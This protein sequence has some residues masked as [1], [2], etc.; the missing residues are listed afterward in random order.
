MKNKRENVKHKFTADFETTTAKVSKTHTRVWAWSVCNIYDHD[1]IVYGEDIGSFIEFAF[2]CKQNV[3][4][5]HNLK[6]DGIFIIDYLLRNGYTC[7]KQNEDIKDKSFSVLINETNVMY[8]ITVY[9]KKKSVKA[10][11]K[12]RP[13]YNKVK[14]ID[15]LKILPYSVDAI[16]KAFKL[17]LS[18]L[19]V[20]YDLDRPIGH[21]LTDEEREYIKHDVLIM[22]KALKITFESG[23]K[24]ITAGSN[25]L[26]QYKGMK[27]G[28]QNYRRIFPKID[29]NTDKEIRKAYRGGYCYA[30]PIYQN[31]E[32]IGDIR[33]YDKNSM[34]PSQMRYQYL[35]I[36]EPKYFRGEYKGEDRF[37][38]Q[39]LSCKFKIRKGFVPTIQD[40]KSIFYSHNEYLKTS[41][42]IINGIEID[43]PVTLYL[44]N[45]DLELFLKHYEVNDIN[46]FGGYSFNT[47]KGLFD[48][49]VDLHYHTK[50][51]ESGALKQ[52][53]KLK[54]NSLY[55]KF[56]SRTDIITKHAV[57]KY[58]PSIDD[59][60][61]YFEFPTKEDG[62][63][64]YTE[65][66]AEYTP[67]GIA[68]TSYARYELIN[69]IDRLGGENEGSQF[70]YCDTDSLH[71]LGDTD[72]LPKDDAK[73]G[74]WKCESTVRKAK[75][76]RA[77]TYLE[78]E[79][80]GGLLVKVA[81]L[82]KN[83]KGDITFDNFEIGYM[84]DQKLLPKIVRGGVILVNTPFIIKG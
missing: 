62:S 66:D 23:D 3:F 39:K 1:Y 12:R 69:Y 51:T 43:E 24:K 37:Y 61:V 26:S 63:K 83:A 31:R 55:G 76:I 47:V 20:D 50:Q 6:F 56:A 52:L 81:G 19:S 74:F 75:Y 33:V 5:F 32:I 78:E 44:S 35:P 22:A 28:I 59:T 17:P 84:T 80:K 54:L 13:I 21:Q 77:K 70:L 36:G 4:Y 58:D 8:M 40:K 2:R 15:S 25:A 71:I 14:F 38:I 60:R 65:K 27:G 53:A 11:A 18:K 45:L 46:Y 16:A 68:V 7:L 10:D 82:P 30:N 79:D 29:Q 9:F 72:I 42:Y 49:Y 57:L 34:Y 41:A 73:L 48:E 64:E 67:I